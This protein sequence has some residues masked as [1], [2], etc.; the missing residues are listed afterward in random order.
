MKIG[1]KKL[2]DMAMA[3]LVKAKKKPCVPTPALLAFRFGEND[4]NTDFIWPM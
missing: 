2:D 3:R 1:L 4:T